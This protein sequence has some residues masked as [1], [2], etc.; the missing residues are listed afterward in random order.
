MDSKI[1]SEIREILL[2]Y[3]KCD[4]NR[5]TGFERIKTLFENNY[6]TPKVICHALCIY[7]ENG[8]C[9]KEWIMLNDKEAMTAPFCEDYEGA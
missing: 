9:N 5:A 4:S 8:F 2:N 3:D 7:Q 6:P 1:L